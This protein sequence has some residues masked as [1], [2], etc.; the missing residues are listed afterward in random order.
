MGGAHALVVRSADHFAGWGDI[1][2]AGV[3]VHVLQKI[4]GHGSLI[5]FGAGES[6]RP[7]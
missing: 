4:A 5:I 7:M 1:A 3:K 2:D 6:S